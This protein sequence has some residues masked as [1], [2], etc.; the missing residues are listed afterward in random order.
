MSPSFTPNWLSG[1]PAFVLWA[2]RASSPRD[3][4]CARISLTVMLTI[5]TRNT[6]HANHD[7]RSLQVG[8]GSGRGTVV[9]NVLRPSPKQFQILNRPK[10]APRVGHGDGNPDFALLQYLSWL[11]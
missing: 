3:S 5:I 9:V 7:R 11:K 8:C 6:E 2:R 10:L 4:S 1:A